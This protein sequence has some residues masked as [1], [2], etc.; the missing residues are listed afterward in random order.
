M[1]QKRQQQHQANLQAK[2]ERENKDRRE[3]EKIAAFGGGVWVHRIAVVLYP[4]HCR[5]VWCWLPVIYEARHCFAHVFVVQS[6]DVCGGRLSQ[7]KQFI[8]KSRGVGCSGH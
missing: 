6:R 5:V 4:C 8:V 3:K 2:M 1:Q 7:F